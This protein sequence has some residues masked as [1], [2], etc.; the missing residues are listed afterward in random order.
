MRITLYDMD[1]QKIFRT[2]D[3]IAIEPKALISFCEN[4]LKDE[5]LC[6]K[7]EI[8]DLRL[9]YVFDSPYGYDTHPTYNCY[10]RHDAYESVNSPIPFDLSDIPHSEIVVRTLNDGRLRPFQIKHLRIHAYEE[11]L[12]IYMGVR[13][14]GEDGIAQPVYLSSFSKNKVVFQPYNKC[15]VYKKWSLLLN[16]LNRYKEQIMTLCK[17]GAFMALHVS[18]DEFNNAD[19]LSDK[20]VKSRELVRDIFERSLNG[21]VLSPYHPNTSIEASHQL[22]YEI[23]NRL[24][25]LNISN[26]ESNGL[27]QKIIKKQPLKYDDLIQLGTYIIDKS[28]MEAVIKNFK[29]QTKDSTIYASVSF[30]SNID[31]NVYTALLYANNMLHD[32]R[33]KPFKNHGQFL[34]KAVITNTD[35]PHQF[36][37]CNIMLQN[38]GGIINL[39]K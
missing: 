36:K 17:N 27:C 8:I 16:F 14:V 39:I 9:K 4:K 22:A 2:Y 33:I 18:G 5:G 32:N 10:T 35:N 30:R 31:R 23:K 25:V 28:R 1:N 7:D 26:K 3:T 15:R 13:K 24:N 20:E 11:G 34:V 29:K 12:R 21:N 6:A 38:I 37:S 19:I